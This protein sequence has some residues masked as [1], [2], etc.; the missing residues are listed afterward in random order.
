[1]HNLANAL[2]D[3]IAHFK[4]VG[5]AWCDSPIS[6]PPEPREPL[7]SSPSLFLTVLR[8]LCVSWNQPFLSFACFWTSHGLTWTACFLS[9]RAAS[10][11]HQLLPTPEPHRL[12]LLGRWALE[13]GPPTPPPPPGPEWGSLRGL[14]AVQHIVSLCFVLKNGDS[15][16]FFFPDYTKKYK[17]PFKIIQ[18]GKKKSIKKKNFQHS[19]KTCAGYIWLMSFQTWPWISHRQQMID[20]SIDRW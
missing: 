11:I 10:H 7:S 2:G 9:L 6:R 14:A 3:W 16:S 13:Q 18:K 17:D 12:W 4:M 1:M 19:L 20:W 8:L 5:S 15:S